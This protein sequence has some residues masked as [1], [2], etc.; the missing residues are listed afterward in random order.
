M[1]EFSGRGR[2]MK[3]LFALLVVLGL[4]TYLVGCSVESTP[5]PSTEP[6]APAVEEGMPAEPGMPEEGTTPAEPGTTPAEPGD[7][8]PADAPPAESPAPEEGAA[9]G[10]GDLNVELDLNV[11]KAGGDAAPAVDAPAAPEGN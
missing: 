11:D 4:G 5:P 10:T 8:P 1:V 6:P 7:T 2:K 9:A 3:K